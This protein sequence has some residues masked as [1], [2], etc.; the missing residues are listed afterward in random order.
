VKLVGGEGA[1]RGWGA[2]REYECEHTSHL[3]NRERSGWLEYQVGLGE[4]GGCLVKIGHLGA[5]KTSCA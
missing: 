3:M 5:D 2:A 4:E 1:T